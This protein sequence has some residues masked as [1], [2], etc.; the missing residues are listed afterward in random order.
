MVGE[1]HTPTNVDRALKRRGSWEPALRGFRIS[2]LSACSWIPQDHLNAIFAAM[3]AAMTDHRGG[4]AGIVFGQISR[5]CDKL[6]L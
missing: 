4:L 6:G 3:E 1:S 5:I 2:R